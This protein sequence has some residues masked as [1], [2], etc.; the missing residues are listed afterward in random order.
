[1]KIDSICNRCKKNEKHL[2]LTIIKP[3]AHTRRFK[4][5]Q[6]WI[7]TLIGLKV[8]L[9]FF[10][11]ESN[12]LVLSHYLPSMT[13]SMCFESHYSIH[14]NSM[15]DIPCETFFWN[16][17][18]RAFVASLDVLDVY[19]NKRVLILLFFFVRFVFLSCTPKA[20]PYIHTDDGWFACLWF[21]VQAHCPLFSIYV[22][23]SSY[24]TE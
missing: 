23:A 9:V 4:I 24:P 1:M 14:F 13:H 3:Q 8:S 11:F 21:C 16:W 7:D 6:R 10:W 15:H 20:L 18:E 5:F 2:W 17:I 12:E 22:R 19:V